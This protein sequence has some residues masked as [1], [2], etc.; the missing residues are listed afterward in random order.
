[1]PDTVPFTPELLAPAGKPETFFAA[2]AAGADAVYLGLDRFNARLK[3]E[4]FSLKDLSRLIPYAH[5]RG[6][7]VFVAMNTLIKQAE[8]PEAVSLVSGLAALGADGL[9]AADW[10]LIALV[11]DRFPDFRLHAS[12]Q[13]GI[14]NSAGTA[15][16]ERLGFRRVILA[17]ELSHEELAL[18]RARTAIELEVFVHGALCYSLSGFC[19]A[20]S[21]IGGASG[22]RGLCTQVCRRGFFRGADRE[23]PFFSPR[24]L[25]LLDAVPGL[26]SLKI[27]AF[28]IEGRLKGGAY[29]RTVVSAYR[30]AIDDPASIPDL[31]RELARDYGRKKTSFFFRAT[32]GTKN[33][34]II[35]DPAEPAAVGML[36]GEVREAHDR[37][38]VVTI[39]EPKADTPENAAAERIGAGDSIRFQPRDGYEGKRYTAAAATAAHGQVEIVFHTPVSAHPGDQ[40]F[41]AD[42]PDPAAHEPRRLPPPRPYKAWPLPKAIAA[43]LASGPRRAPGAVKSSLHLVIDHPDWLAPA[44]ATEAE[45]IVFRLPEPDPVAAENLFGPLDQALKKRLVAGL[46]VFIPETDMDRWRQTIR[47]AL[48]IG[49]TRFACGNAGSLF[50][51]FPDRTSGIGRYAE[52]SVNAINAPG[53]GLL[54]TLGAELVTG[55]WEDD[56]PNLRNGSALPPAVL[57]YGL[58]PLFVSRVDPGVPDR[59]KLSDRNRNAFIAVRQGRLFYLLSRDPLC[60]FQKK[61]KLAAIGVRDFIIDLSFQRPDAKLLAG[62]LAAFKECR[63]LLPSTLFNFKRELI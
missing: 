23:V 56:F 12:T 8:L 51:L 30:R 26:F 19:L 40:A 9:I 52:P 37:R 29:V 53:R 50:G 15:L 54:R 33:E 18:V 25:E 59:T 7:K 60:L 11:R 21:F 28:K 35:Q 48:N 31:K 4:N 22:N 41:L 55:S 47:A 61:E 58:V 32:A 62:V 16:A 10:G 20:S 57:M 13:L 1:M 3:S 27:N 38:V 6:K 5:E 36:V 49:V 42:R 2:L 39:K 24:D 34:G 14:H 43:V 44:A 46:P 45:R 63:R 17:R